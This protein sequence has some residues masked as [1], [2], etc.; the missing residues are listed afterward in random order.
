MPTDELTSSSSLPVVELSKEEIEKKC[1]L[2]AA[3]RKQLSM[4]ATLDE[5]DENAFVNDTHLRYNPW[6][7]TILGKVYQETRTQKRERR[8]PAL[9]QSEAYAKWDRTGQAPGG[10]YGSL[11][12]VELEANAEKKFDNLRKKISSLST[13]ESVHMKTSEQKQPIESKI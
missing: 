1:C 13:V 7:K 5:Y 3:L 9:I 2:T 12:I 6:S 11:Q 10:L 4:E 8:Q